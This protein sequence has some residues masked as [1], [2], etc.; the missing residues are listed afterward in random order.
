MSPGHG[1]TSH[2]TPRAPEL[3]DSRRSGTEMGD[4][5]RCAPGTIVVAADGS[6]ARSLH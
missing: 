5:I 4:L 3:W 2:P 1:F 6:L